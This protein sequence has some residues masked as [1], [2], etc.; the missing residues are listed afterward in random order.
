MIC[1]NC[2]VSDMNLILT[3]TLVWGINTYRTVL[4]LY[5]LSFTATPDLAY[6]ISS[7]YDSRAATP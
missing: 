2:N 1:A 3:F 7:I 6:T 4:N 5:N